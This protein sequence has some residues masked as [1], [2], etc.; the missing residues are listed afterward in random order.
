[1]S[2]DWN[3]KE[4]RDGMQMNQDDRDILIRL[5]QNVKNFIQSMDQHMLDDKASFKKQGDD[6]EWL[7]K[8]TY[9]GLGG[10][11]VVQVI[12]QFLK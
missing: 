1:M 6:I 7:K 5:D 2:S 9:M 10:I 4:R 8:V 11:A 3:G 12:I